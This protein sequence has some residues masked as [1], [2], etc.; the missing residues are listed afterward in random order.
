MSNRNSVVR[1]NIGV[2]AHQ[3]ALTH[4]RRRLLFR[5]GAR[6]LGSPQARQTRLNCARCHQH[7]LSPLR[8]LLGD[9]GGKG[10]DVYAVRSGDNRR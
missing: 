8:A 7:D 4:A 5:Y 1:E 6:A 2:Q 10:V 3:D 9:L